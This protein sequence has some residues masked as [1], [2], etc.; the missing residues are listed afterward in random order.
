MPGQAYCSIPLRTLRTLFV[1]YLSVQSTPEQ[2][3]CTAPDHLP[4]GAIC[5]PS[6]QV[7]SA[8]AYEG[9]LANARITLSGDTRRSFIRDSVDAAAAAVGGEGH[10]DALV[11][12]VEQI[13][14]GCRCM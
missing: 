4:A 14:V 5:L 2:D 7:A 8:E 12:L 11:C 10:W 9:V 1:Q 13:G 6:C 3:A